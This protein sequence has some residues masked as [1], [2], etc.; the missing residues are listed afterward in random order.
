MN[1]QTLVKMGGVTKTF[2]GVVATDKIDFDH[3]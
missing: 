1:D 2:P 3:P